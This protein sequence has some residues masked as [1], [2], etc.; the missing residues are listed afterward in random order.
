MEIIVQGTGESFYTPNQV[1]LS[2]NFFV[3]ETNYDEAL[4]NGSANVLEFV[5]TLL[6]AHGFT[7]EDMKTNSFL[8]RKETKYNEST[9]TYD[10]VG[11]SYNQNATLKFDYDKEKLS[12]IMEEISKMSKPPFYKVDFTVKDI[13]AC[14]RDNLTKAYKDAEEQAQI[15]AEASGKTLKHCAR[16]DFKPFTTEYVSRG[17]DSDMVYGASKDMAKMISKTSSAET[18]NA[19][20]TP[21]DVEISETLYCLWIAE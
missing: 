8:I 14:K 7:K 4:A 15:I 12:V 18:I 21:Q 2:L 19:V 3:K 9:K 11:Y 5:N 10:F 20:F 1:I 16:T 17:Y 6:S 13:K